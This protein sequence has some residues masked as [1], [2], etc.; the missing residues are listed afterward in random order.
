[1]TASDSDTKSSDTSN[2][3]IRGDVAFV[4]LIL[5]FAGS[6]LNML[7]S[8][9]LEH[10]YFAEQQSQISKKYPGFTGSCLFNLKAIFRY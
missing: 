8:P 7:F 2:S 1:M 6:I 9:G 3:Y 4:W 5:F 10:V